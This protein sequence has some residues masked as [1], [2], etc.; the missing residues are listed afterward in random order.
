MILV[1]LLLLKI[2]VVIDIIVVI[3]KYNFFI[4]NNEK[5]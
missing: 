2:I 4:H 5:V 3:F 1:K